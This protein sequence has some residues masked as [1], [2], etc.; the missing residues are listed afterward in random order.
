[1]LL[2]KINIMFISPWKNLNQ[3]PKQPKK[4]ITWIENKDLKIINEEILNKTLIIKW[5][6]AY[7]EL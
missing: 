6:L 2:K 4:K 1:M 3:T 5:R 7:L